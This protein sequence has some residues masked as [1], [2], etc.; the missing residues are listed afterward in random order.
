[1]LRSS[2]TRFRYF[3]GHLCQRMSGDLHLAG[4]TKRTHAGDLYSV[5]QVP[6][7]RLQTF[8]GPSRS[9]I[10]IR[11]VQGLMVWN[12]VVAKLCLAVCRR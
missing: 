12:C 8:G 5:C 7:H 10:R 9:F 3:N 1:M 11:E 2:L 6:D 4:M